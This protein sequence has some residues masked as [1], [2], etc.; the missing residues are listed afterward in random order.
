VDYAAVVTFSLALFGL[1]PPLLGLR[2][3]Q[4]GGSSRANTW[5]FRLALLA[6]L[7][8]G[9]GNLL[10]DGLGLGFV[11]LVIYLPASLLLPAGLLMFGITTIR[12]RVLP[13]WCG[14]MLVLAVVGLFFIDIGG[15]FVVGAACLVLAYFLLMAHP[16]KQPWSAA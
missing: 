7:A 4:R 2:A 8:A 3:P 5:G 10:E 15:G 9:L 16:T 14:W 6:A 13:P 1:C 12:A 11:G